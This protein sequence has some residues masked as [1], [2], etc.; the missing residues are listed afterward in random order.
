MIIYDELNDYELVSMAQEQNE[1]AIDLLH[2]KYQPV[3]YRKCRKMLKILHNKGIEL[4]DLIQEGNLAVE[5]AIQNFNPIDDV[6]FYTFVNL[7]IDRQLINILNI[8]NRNKHKILNEAMPLENNDDSEIS[9]IDIIEDNSYNP[10]REIITEEQLKELYQ[11]IMDE[12][13]NFESFVFGLRMQGLSYKEIADVLDK[14]IKSVD[15]AVQRIKL[16][17]K[18][19]IEKRNSY[20]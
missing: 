2:K 9:L 13:T 8:T 1:D 10:E 14:D 18:C 7:C 3:I 19:I 5:L 6:S 12:L 11:D 17:I 20:E 15:N 16:K 4:S